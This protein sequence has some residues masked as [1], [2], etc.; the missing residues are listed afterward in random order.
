MAIVCSR[1][2]FASRPWQDLDP[3]RLELEQR[4]AADHLARRLDE[5][6]DRLD[7]SAFRD[8]YGRSG[9]AAYPGLFIPAAR[10]L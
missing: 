3:R 4:L 8:A 1:P 2:R 10:R 5:A 6:V 9:S 7:L